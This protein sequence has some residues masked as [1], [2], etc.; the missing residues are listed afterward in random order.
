METI[1]SAKDLSTR[2]GISKSMVCRLAQRGHIKGRLLSSG[3]IFDLPEVKEYERFAQ[4]KVMRRYCVP[5][6]L[7]ELAGV[8]MSG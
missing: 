5:E 3:W 8:V 4:Y 6:F 2:W 1:L 7:Q